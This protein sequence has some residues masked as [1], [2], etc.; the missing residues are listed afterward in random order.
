MGGV[1]AGAVYAVIGLIV[2]KTGHGW[3]ETRMPPVLT[4]AIV[5][6]IGL[7]PAPVAEQ[8]V[9]GSQFNVFFGLL[10]VAL[11]AFSA[12]YLHY[13]LACNL[14]TLGKP[15]DFSKIS[16]AEWLG[17]PQFTP[18]AFELNAMLLVAPV[19]IILVAENLGHV[20]AISAMTGRWQPSSP[21]CCS[22]FWR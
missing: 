9:S 13:F 11:V 2:M 20:R 1:A 18:P 5:T 12:A 7:N 8:Q 3:I 19:A 4:G 14:S 15:I 10:T 17:S 6:K 22:T 21:W 16:G